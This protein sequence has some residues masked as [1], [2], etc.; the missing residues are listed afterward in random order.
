MSFDSI[1]SF[2]SFQIFIY[3]TI[4]PNLPIP[5]HDAYSVVYNSQQWIF[6]TKTIPAMRELGNFWKSGHILRGLFSKD[7]CTVYKQMRQNMPKY[8]KKTDYLGQLA[9]E[10]RDDILYPFFHKNRLLLESFGK[11]SD[12]DQ[13]NQLSNKAI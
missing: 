1:Q 10:G 11:Y 2:F 3:W 12:F 7:L 9:V 5:S 4:S 8:A 13:S 6:N